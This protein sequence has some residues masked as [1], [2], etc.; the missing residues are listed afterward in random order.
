[1]YIFITLRSAIIFVRPPLIKV[2]GSATV[3]LKI[4]EVVTIVLLLTSTSPTT[5]NTML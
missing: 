2:P 3:D 1:M 5:K 4:N